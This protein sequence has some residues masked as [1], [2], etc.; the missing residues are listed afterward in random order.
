MRLRIIPF[1]LLLSAC[2]G[3]SPHFMGI[4]PTRVTVDGS[5]FA[6]RVKGEQA[7]AVRINAQYA[8]RMG[9]IGARAARAME[10]VSGCTVR[11]IRGDQALI[12]GILDC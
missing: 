4:E 2:D 8:P 9:P 7:E 1:L 6:V 12:L 11:E 5:T 10:Q 3:G